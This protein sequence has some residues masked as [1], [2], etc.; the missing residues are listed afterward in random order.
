[1]GD[2]YLFVP[3]G[4]NPT[5][6]TPL[7]LGLH[8]AGGNVT[9]QLALLE[10][11]AETL[12]FLIVAVNSTGAT[13]DAI[14]GRFGPDVQRIDTALEQAFARC[15][16]DPARIAIEGFSDGASYALGVGIANG[17]LFT[18]IVAFSPG[19]VPGNDSSRQGS[20][21]VFVS[22]GL[23]DPV[24]PIQSTSRIIVPALQQAGY[25][26]TYREFAG[27]HTIPAGVLDEAVAWVL[28]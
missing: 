14:S 8:G 13:W 15:R 10:S 16:V 23:E 6:P 5:V 17:S 1:M 4:Y 12:G 18:R 27:G 22:H 25:Q 19:Y 20:P 21:E 28:R 11:R 24:L 26:V 9:Q 7:V 2:G 3:A